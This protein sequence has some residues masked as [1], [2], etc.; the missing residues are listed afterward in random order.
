MPIRWLPRLGGVL[1]LPLITGACGFIFMHGPPENNQ[2]LP[3]FSCTESNTGAILDVVGVGLS[4]VGVAAALAEDGST[5]DFGPD[6]E[7]VIG[8]NVVWA[9]FL[10]ASAAT[11]F[12]K[13]KKCRAA[14]LDLAKRQ[15]GS[16]TN[17][18]PWPIELQLT[19]TLPDA[20]AT[21]VPRFP[22]QPIYDTTAVAIAE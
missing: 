15:H 12:N 17:M 19:R 22:L 4:V 16:S 10:G 2:E 20:L 1:L 7:A 6:R 14:K 11:G 3:Y 18:A 5:N 9:V 8:V 21:G 13:S